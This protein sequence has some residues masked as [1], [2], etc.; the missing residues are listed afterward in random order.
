MKLSGKPLSTN[1]EAIPSSSS[2]C[3]RDMANRDS[4]SD[5]S[6][7]PQRKSMRAII[8]GKIRVIKIKRTLM[9]FRPAP[10]NF[11]M[12]KL[13]IKRDMSGSGPVGGGRDK[14]RKKCWKLSKSVGTMRI[15]CPPWQIECSY[16]FLQG[17][18]DGWM[19]FTRSQIIPFLLAF[20]P[21]LESSLE[22][23][24]ETDRQI[25]R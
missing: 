17:F 12:G 4:G 2:F 14:K 11:Q 3:G 24:D 13:G 7:I 16:F 23:T 8:I 21:F 18:P 19:Q 6:P 20:S 25:D 5:Y 15:R 10:G 1:I 9:Q 22:G